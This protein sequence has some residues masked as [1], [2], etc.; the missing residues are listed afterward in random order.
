LSKS[1]RNFWL[2]VTAS[3]LIILGCIFASIYEN[4][5]NSMSL[6]RLQRSLNV[7]VS[8]NNNK[9]IISDTTQLIHGQKNGDF[10]VSLQH[11]ANYHL[12]RGTSLLNLDQYSSAMIDFRTATALDSKLQI[13]ALQGEV[14]A[15]YDMGE[16][17]QLIPVLQE[18]A[19]LNGNGD[20]SVDIT[21]A[22]YQGDIQSIENN[23][24]PVL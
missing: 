23:Q 19:K 6:Q 17:R 7:A 10:N 11:L 5:N 18:L 16:R 2:T 12:D 14:I 13:A 22:Q 1:R 8:D 20:N 15:G 3:I 21:A 4:H 24:E 9:L